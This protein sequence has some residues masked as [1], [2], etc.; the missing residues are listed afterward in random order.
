MVVFKNKKTFEKAK[1]LRN[2][3]RSTTKVFWHDYA[4]FNFRMTNIQAAIGLAQLDRLKKF[5]N[6]K[7]KVFLELMTIYLRSIMTLF[8]FQKINGQP[9]HFGYT[10]FC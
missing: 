2:Q 1:K 3:G 9:I 10:L 8:C 6:S 7:K 4:G 5:F